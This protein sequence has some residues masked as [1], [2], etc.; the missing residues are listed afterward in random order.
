[1][2][3]YKDIYMLTSADVEG[4]YRYAGKI[5]TLSEAKAD[6]LIKEGQ[7]K[8]PYN[9][10]ENH[11]R[12][13]AE[14]LGEDFDKEIEAIRSNE[15]L[16]DEARQEDIK[17]LIEKFDKEYNLTQYLYTKSIDEGLESAKR[18]EGIAPLKAVNQFDAEKVRQEVG[19]MMSELIM[20]NDFTEAVS[21]LERKVEVSDREIARELLS[22]FVTIKSQLDELNQG[23]SV[24]RAMSNTKVRSLYEDL[25]RT[26]ADEKQV[27]ASS[28][29]ALYSALRDHRNDI[30]W[31]WR[32]KKI[33]M[34]TAKKRSL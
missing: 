28:K 19:V 23:D 13:K 20:A 4:G 18:I 16:T 14:K 5:Y 3:N 17:S 8:H 7:A 31:K 10:S 15:R 21:Y 6:E 2:T 1:M 22:R 34:E 9:S 25:K 29:I 24:A 27:E 11:W 12:E 26:A 33:A 32:Q 30:T